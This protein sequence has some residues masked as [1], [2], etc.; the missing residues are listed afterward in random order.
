[1]GY[2]KDVRGRLGGGN[3]EAHAHD[4]VCA[5]CVDDDG[6]RGLIESEARAN[7][8]TFCGAES[9]DPIA[10]PLVEVLLHINDVYRRGIRCRGEQ[11]VLRQ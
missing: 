1:M 7:C 5:A 11:A 10:A 8:C 3:P 2:W 4:Y 9:A 6:L